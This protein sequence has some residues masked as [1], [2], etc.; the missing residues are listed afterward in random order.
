MSV[1]GGASDELS[2]V[3]D[4]VEMERM[5]EEVIGRVKRELAIEHERNGG[6]QPSFMG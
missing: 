6:F 3:A 2:S 4:Q 1:V 5:V